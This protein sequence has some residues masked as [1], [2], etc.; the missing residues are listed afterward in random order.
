VGVFGN[1]Q[2]RNLLRGLDQKTG[3]AQIVEK[4]GGGFGD[5][6]YQGTGLVTPKKKPE[7]GELTMRII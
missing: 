2:Q 3:A 4:S 7:G 5:K 1:E 6:G